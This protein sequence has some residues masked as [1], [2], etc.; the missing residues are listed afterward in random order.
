VIAE[1]DKGGVSVSRGVEL[2]DTLTLQ[3]L[4]AKGAGRQEEATH[5]EGQGEQPDEESIQQ[6]RQNA[7]VVQSIAV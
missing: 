2:V 4:L 1:A 6:E 5:G 7:P 3:F